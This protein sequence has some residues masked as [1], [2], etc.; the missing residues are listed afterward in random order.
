MIS[1]L[2]FRPP[3]VLS[4]EGAKGPAVFPLEIKIFGPGT[5]KRAIYALRYRAFI[6]A[7]LISQRDD[8]LFADAYDELPTT[9]TIAAFDAVTCV[10]S[11]RLTFGQGN[12]AGDTMPCQEIFPEVGHLAD[13]GYGRIVEFTRMVVAPELTNTSFRTT[14]YAALVRAG[15]IVAHA[16]RAD[17]GL[18]SINPSQVRF[19]EMMCG[20]R[21]LAR[22]EN[23]PGI[24]APAVLL[25]CDFQ[26]L[27]EKRTRQNPFFRLAPAEI[28]RARSIL[29]PEAHREIAVA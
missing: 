4:R 3:L 26:A 16:A 8:A 9:T 20:F 15:L 7:G 13:G 12:P 6:E 22:A 10:G 17:Y 23:Y 21:E 27:D 28:T 18:I 25:G 5:D 1:D 11:F 24:N 2:S 19:Y 29:Y 14:L